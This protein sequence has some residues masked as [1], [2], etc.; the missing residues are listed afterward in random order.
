MDG[1]Y[2]WSTVVCAELRGWKLIS[3]SA[4]GQAMEASIAARSR[5]SDKWSRLIWEPPDCRYC[6]VRSDVVPYPVAR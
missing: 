2:G 6:V 4:R 5:H 1:N 3:F